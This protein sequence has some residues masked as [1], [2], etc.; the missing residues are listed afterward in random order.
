MPFASDSACHPL[1]L[2]RRWAPLLALALVLPACHRKGPSSPATAEIHGRVL[3]ANGRALPGASAAV[4]RES[5]AGKVEIARAT[6]GPNG[7]FT[8]A[9]LP[10]G[11]YRVRTEAPG[12]ATVTVPVEL[13]AG[14]SV[15][16]SLRFEPEQLLEGVVQDSRGKPL[17]DALVLA[18]PMGKR[19]GTL[20]EAHSGDDGRFT[21]AGLPRGSWTLL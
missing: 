1:H 19:Q 4:E 12:Y 6:L 8:L 9:N 20:L 10:P 5:T 17:A 3:T 15:T 14:D 18:W 13:A 16:T 2:R 11:R 7:D 21:L